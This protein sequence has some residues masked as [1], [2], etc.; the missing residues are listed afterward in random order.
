MKYTDAQKMAYS[1]TPARLK[2]DQLIV[3]PFVLGAIFGIGY[4]MATILIKS[5]LLGEI[6]DLGR[7]LPAKK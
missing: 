1:S 3:K 7:E 2:L 6:L 5:P 4:Y